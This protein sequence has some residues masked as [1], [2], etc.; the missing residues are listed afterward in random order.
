MRKYKVLKSKYYKEEDKHLFRSYGFLYYN[1]KHG[2]R[3]AK[4]LDTKTW[5]LKEVVKNPK[6]IG[7][8]FYTEKD[9]KAYAD[10]IH[11]LAEAGSQVIFETIDQG[12]C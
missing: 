8:W 10:Y 3:E 5:L 11:K 7:D 12:G 2:W 1:T 4:N 6:L 9:K